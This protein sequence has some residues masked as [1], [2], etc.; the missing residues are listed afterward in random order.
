MLAMS[1]FQFTQRDV[2]TV[3]VLVAM[4]AWSAWRTLELSE[5]DR[6]ID[7]LRMEAAKA[8]RDNDRTTDSLRNASESQYQWMLYWEADAK[9]IREFTEKAGLTVPA[10]APKP[11]AVQVGDDD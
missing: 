4:V 2:V 10:H 3:L 9:A 6:L 1:R 7:R 11:G 8:K 5:K